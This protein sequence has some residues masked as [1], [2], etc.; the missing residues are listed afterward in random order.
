VDND[1][2]IQNAEE[3]LKAKNNFYQQI[4]IVYRR[5]ESFRD[6]GVIDTSIVSPII[7]YFRE[8]KKQKDIEDQKFSES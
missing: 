2:T 1:L 3:K 7:I 5:I 8:K 4:R 6:N